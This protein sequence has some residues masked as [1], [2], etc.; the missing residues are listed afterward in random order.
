MRKNNLVLKNMQARKLSREPRYRLN[1]ICP[2]YT[3]FP[4]EFPMKQLSNVSR[5]QV[6]LDVFC[7]RGTTN[8]AAQ[9]KGIKSYGVDASP[10]A[11]AIAKAKLSSANNESVMSLLD[12]I[13]QEFEP[14]DIPEGDFWELGFHEETLYQI[15]TVRTALSVLEET[16]ETVSLTALMLGCLH[17]P[18][19]TKKNNASYFSNQMPRTFSSKPSYSVR[20]WRKNRLRPWKID[21][22]N[23]LNKKAENT[24]KEGFPRPANIQNIVFGDSRKCDLRKI[25]DEYVDL[26]IT[27]PPYYGMRTYIQDQWLRNWFL[28]GTSD[29]DYFDGYS[30]DHS[31]PYEFSKSLAKVWDNIYNVASDDIKMV[32]RFGSISSRKADPHSIINDSLEKSAG[33]WRIYYRREV[34][35]SEMGYR[36]ANTMGRRAE[37]IALEEYDYFIRLK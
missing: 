30:M 12:Y 22:R 8:F 16:D 6:V 3:M 32:I 7:G 37:S 14:D 10:V 9:T 24:L 15:C 29:I 27:S 1:A 35:S 21:I 17:G 26:V 2:Y 34:G 20:Y 33:S 25:V 13:L 28:G 31:S 5:D 36:Q 4:L 19:T 18:K 11:V 23:P